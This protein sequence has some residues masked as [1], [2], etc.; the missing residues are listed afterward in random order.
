VARF[1]HRALTGFACNLLVGAGLDAPLATDV[2]QVLVEGD[3]LGHDTHGLALL[4]PYLTEIDA[5]RMTRAGEPTSLRERTVTALWD[6][7]RLPGPAL[8][9]RAIAW[10]EPRARAHGTASVVIRRSHHIAALAAYLEP[11]ARAGLFIELLCSDP[12]TA[13]VAPAGGT[14]P[15]FTPDPVAWGIP[16]GADP[17]LIDTSASLTTNGMSARLAQSGQR[18]AH[19]FWLTAAGEATDDPTVLTAKPP[20]TILPVGGVEAGH[21]GYGL[22]LMNEARSA[23]LAGHGRADPREGWGATVYLSLT[24]PEAFAGRT[25]FAREMD[26]LVAACRTNAPRDASQPV[27][28]PGERALARKRHQL[29]H[30]VELSDAI[31]SAVGPWAERLRVNWPA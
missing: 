10:A 23:A 18:G 26:H 25:A 16:T 1:E 15:V 8:V 27:R 13:S 2:A 9:R 6:G 14:Q 12:N 21:K 28:L 30:G 11:V 22:A 24:D 3:L 17:I 7:A 19:R 5:G 31:V 4:A 20:G 29:A